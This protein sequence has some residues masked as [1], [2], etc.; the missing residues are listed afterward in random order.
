[1][2]VRLF[3]ATQKEFTGYRGLLYYRNIKMKVG[4]ML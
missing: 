3:G 2:I 1:M 4:S